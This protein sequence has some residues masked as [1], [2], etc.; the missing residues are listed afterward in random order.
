[1]LLVVRPLFAASFV[2]SALILTAIGLALLLPIF[3]M[4]AIGWGGGSGRSA[5][6]SLVLYSLLGSWITNAVSL[7]AAVRYV[8]VLWSLLSQEEIIFGCLAPFLFVVLVL[9]RNRL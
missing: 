3:L 7:V 5:K 6:D 8:K 4:L 9:F 2:L 1:L